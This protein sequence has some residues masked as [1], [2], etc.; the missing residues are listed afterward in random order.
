MDLSAMYAMGAHDMMDRLDGSR[1]P[2]F[3]KQQLNEV[4]SC[5]EA[6]A[7]TTS[8]KADAKV[9]VQQGVPIGTFEHVGDFIDL[10]LSSTTAR[11]QVRCKIVD[12]C[13]YLI[14]QGI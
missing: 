9:D 4:M 11:E 12:D 13:P 14:I 2:Q 1:K 5:L 3:A 10:D 7:G 6:L 8:G